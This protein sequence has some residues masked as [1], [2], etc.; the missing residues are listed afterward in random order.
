MGKKLTIALPAEAVGWAPR[1]PITA[2]LAGAEMLRVSH[3]SL[4]VSCFSSLP[5]EVGILFGWR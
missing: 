5:R 2:F 4:R 3:F 1:P